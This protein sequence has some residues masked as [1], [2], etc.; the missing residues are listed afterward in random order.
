[1]AGGAPVDPPRSASGATAERTR[2]LGVVYGATAY[3]LW[4]FLPL[5]FLTLRPAGPWEVVAWR[6][7][8]SLAFC[9]LLLAVLRAW[10]RFWTVLR[11]PRL[12]ALTAL[13]AVLIYVNWQVFLIGAL[14][15]H[16]IETSLGYF[17]TPIV[18]ALLGVFVLRERLRIM[19]WIAIGIA[20]CAVLVIIVG[21]GSVPWFA[22]T[23]AFSFGLYGLVKKQIGPQVD[24]VSGLTLETAWLVPVA[25][26]QL[27]VVGLTAGLVFGTAGPLNTVLLALAGV[28]TATPLLLFASGARRVPLTVMGLLQFIAPIFQFLTGVLL[29]HEP[30][31]PERWIGFCLVW[32]ALAV[33]S[34]DIVVHSRRSR[35]DDVADMV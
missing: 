20:V 26:V 28:V 8:F 4:G 35:I 13:A 27:I 25:V 16:V 10:R 3:L 5:Y 31:P 1:M 22:L 29:L 9:V 11:T 34:V 6:I 30:M 2:I 18:V 23:L 15:G 7:V 19:Q 17:I 24:A 32:V 33:I 21:Y 12:L 14:T